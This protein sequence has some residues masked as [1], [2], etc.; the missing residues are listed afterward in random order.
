MT[1]RILARLLSLSL[2]LPAL[3]WAA[4]TIPVPAEQRQALGI[5]S[6]P[7]TL[8]TNNLGL[9]ATAKV[10][11]PPASVRVI[12]APT[13]GLVTTLLHQSG[14]TVSSGQALIALSSP[15]LVDA[16]R[17][18]IQANLKY[19][20][21]A[22]MA[23]RD[24]KLV[25]EGLIAETRWTTSQNEAALA[26]ADVEA[27][28]ATLK[29]LGAKPDGK[30]AEITLTS[31]M[32][33][34]ILETMTE[35]GQRVDAS[36][37]L[38]KIGNLDKLG[39]EIPL[40]PEQA[41][42]VAKGQSL[43]VDGGKAS[44]TIRALQPALDNAQNVI[45]RADIEPAGTATLHP[46]QNVKVKLQGATGS[47]TA[48]S[49]PTSGLVWMGDKAYVFTESATGFTPTPVTL[50]NQDGQQAS[51]SGLSADSRI[52]IQGVAALKAKWQEAGE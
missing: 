33:G 40:T 2:S 19:N 39:L 47:K 13:D 11:L 27:A 30:G 44:G 9:E 25:A 22:D 29:L 41:K 1:P 48:L 3:G 20:L 24:R 8:A 35:P 28:R 51:V 16:R 15:Q 45:V 34:T 32:D 46:G 42:S 18:Y 52:A 31:P 23:A 12:A 6:A 36:T 49:I 50:I 38:I 21:A 4:E 10:V 5:E 7:A 26:S 43:E 37:P 17:Q 14:E